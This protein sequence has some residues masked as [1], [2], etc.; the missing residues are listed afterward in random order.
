MY[1]IPIS[2][3]EFDKIYSWK[4]E[5]TDDNFVVEKVFSFYTEEGPPF[6]PFDEGWQ[7]RKKITID[8]NKV[9]GNLDNFPV[10]ISI[11]D[12]DL[13]NKAQNDGDD[14]LFM[15]SIGVASK[16]YYEIENY[17]GST[18]ELIA[19]VKVPILSSNDDT[20]FYMYYGN[21]SCSSQ[22]FPRKVWTPDF[23]A[24]YHMSDNGNPQ[25]S[26]AFANHVTSTTGTPI[27]GQPGIVH[28]AI[29]YDGG[30]KESDVS[31]TFPADVL[32]REETEDGCSIEAWVKFDSLTSVDYYHIVTL[33]RNQYIGMRL[34]DQGNDDLRLQVWNKGNGVN[35]M[36]NGETQIT[37]TSKFY[38]M[39]WTYEGI[40]DRTQVLYLDSNIDASEE[41]NNDIGQIS[42]NN[43][44]GSN[45]LDNWGTQGII[46]EIRISNSARIP[47]WIKTTYNTI[48]DPSSFFSIGPE[49]I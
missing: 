46:D 39:A 29:Y 41:G 14:I 13:K 36:I 23:K 33:N 32:S 48:S 6:D 11:V 38:Y 37:S 35:Y 5:V 43:K 3:L 24:V 42:Y 31:H 47:S 49:E 9:A 10:L 4:V 16:C 19:W 12:S 44:I 15:N 21:P 28:S 17:D 1:S 2:G 27:Y 22:E 34:V 26:T 18:G 8:Y 25:D 45:Y 40:T 20:I 7:Y 30:T